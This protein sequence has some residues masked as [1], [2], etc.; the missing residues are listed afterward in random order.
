VK[1]KKKTNERKKERKV[2]FKCDQGN[3]PL[4][5]R[6]KLRSTTHENEKVKFKTTNKT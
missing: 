1:E 2:L 4:K 6:K 5:K 3:E